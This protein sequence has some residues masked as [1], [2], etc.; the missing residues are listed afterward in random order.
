MRDP[1]PGAVGVSKLCVYDTVTPDGLPGGTPHLHLC[2]TEAYVVSRRHGTG[3]DPLRPGR[4]RGARP[5]ARHRP[6]VHARHHPPPDQP[7][8]PGDHRA[9][10]Q[11]RPP[12]GGRRG[13]HLPARHRGA[14]P[15]ATP[16]P[17]RSRTAAPPAP[18]SP[19]PTAAATS[20]SRASTSCVTTAPLDEFYAAAMKLKQPLLDG[21]RERWEHGRTRRPRSDR[22]ADRR[23]RPS[24]DP[25]HLRR[26]TRE[27][28]SRE[29]DEAGRLGMCG[30]LNTYLDRTYG[31]TDHGKALAAS[32]FGQIESWESACLAASPTAGGLRAQEVLHNRV[33]FAAGP[34]R[35]RG[36]GRVRAGPFLRARL[37]QGQRLRPRLDPGRSA[38]DH[39][40]RRRTRLP[41]HRHRR[42]RTCSPTRA[43]PRSTR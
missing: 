31:T 24:G 10:E 41:G 19:P 32:R 26:I 6:L 9:H 5:E 18:T 43:S 40:A 23:A 14:T 35:H 38:G 42:R 1:L 15:T 11:H 16:R 3:A 8:R 30:L 20:P 28:A 39:R 34:R 13:A 29:P 22:P 36:S 33:L 17:S 21:W 12:G 37:L 2:C 7:R 25:G 27:R 4:L